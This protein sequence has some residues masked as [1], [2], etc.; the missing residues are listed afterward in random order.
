MRWTVHRPGPK[1]LVPHP[2]DPN[3]VIRHY[4]TRFRRQDVCFPGE[5]FCPKCGWRVP[6]TVKVLGQKNIYDRICLSCRQTE[7]AEERGRRLFARK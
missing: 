4:G 7:V 1:H 5:P 2:P 3:E 6:D